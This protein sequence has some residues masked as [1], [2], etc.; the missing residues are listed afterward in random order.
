MWDDLDAAILTGPSGDQ[1]HGVPVLLCNWLLRVYPHPSVRLSPS[2][3]AYIKIQ[4]I[5]PYSRVR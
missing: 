2:K 3:S 4:V 1:I 5:Y